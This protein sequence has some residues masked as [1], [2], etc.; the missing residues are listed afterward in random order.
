VKVRNIH[1]QVRVVHNLLYRHDFL[2]G[3][4][5][6]FQFCTSRLLR[7][8]YVS[9]APYEGSQFHPVPR[10]VIPQIKGLR[11]LTP[12]GVMALIRK[13]KK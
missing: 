7:S 4:A 3:P 8:S 12:E 1:L 6:T 5:G 10:S 13:E 2:T 9:F 11:P